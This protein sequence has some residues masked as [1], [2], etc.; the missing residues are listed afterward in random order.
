[1]TRSESFGT[2]R[3]KRP[4]WAAAGLPASDA[5]AAI[6][7][8]FTKTECQQG[9]FM[10]AEDKRCPLRGLTDARNPIESA[11]RKLAL[12]RRMITPPNE[13]DMTRGAG[14]RH[15][16]KPPSAWLG[17]LLPDGRPATDL[18]AALCAFLRS[19]L[20]RFWTGLK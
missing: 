3:Y 17:A 4:T 2:L 18:A 12:G 1:M 7:R 9:F 13:T 11:Q 15:A 16:S 14:K 8:D 19:N 20:K 6:A 5:N 10:A